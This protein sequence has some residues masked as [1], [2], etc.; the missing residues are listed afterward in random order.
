MTATSKSG[1]TFIITKAT[2]TGVITRTC[3]AHA[4][5]GLQVVG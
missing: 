4:T 5:G 2:G 3:T 1:N